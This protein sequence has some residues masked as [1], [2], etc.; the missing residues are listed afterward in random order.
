MLS[1]EAT[2]MDTGRDQPN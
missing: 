2:S 1:P